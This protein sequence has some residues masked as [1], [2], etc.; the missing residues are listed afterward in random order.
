MHV[1]LR[2]IR[3][4]ITPKPNGMGRKKRMRVAEVYGPDALSP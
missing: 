2:K 4:A 1:D 3:A